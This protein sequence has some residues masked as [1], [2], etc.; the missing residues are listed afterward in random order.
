MVRRAIANNEAFELDV[1]ALEQPG[2]VYTADTLAILTNPEVIA[3]DQDAKGVQGRRVWQVGPFEV[4]TR[5]LAD[6]S[7]AVLLMNRG[8]DTEPITVDFKSVALRGSRSVR[9]LWAHK[10]L[11]RFTDKFTA[12]VPRRCV[13]MVKIR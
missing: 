1:T 2:P 3:V 10:D 12:N 7:A 4:W 8:N 9:D 5:P 11:G 13:V 6:G